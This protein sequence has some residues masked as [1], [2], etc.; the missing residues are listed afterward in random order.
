MI[1]HGRKIHKRY[2]TGNRAEIGAQN[3]VLSHGQSR[4]FTNECLRGS[5]L[6]LAKHCIDRHTIEH[7]SLRY[8][9]WWKY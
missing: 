8:T 2:L 1:S 3:V 9:D 5:N 7:G 6:P 4:S